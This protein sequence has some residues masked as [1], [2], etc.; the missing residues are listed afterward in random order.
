MVLDDL[1]QIA[2][3]IGVERLRSSVRDPWL[4][5]RVAAGSAAILSEQPVTIPDLGARENTA[6]AVSGIPLWT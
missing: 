2:V 5:G 6:R 1:E 3:L 4:G